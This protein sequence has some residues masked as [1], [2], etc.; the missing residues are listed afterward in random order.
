MSFRTFSL[1]NGKNQTLALADQSTRIFLNNPQGLGLSQTVNVTQFGNV[2]K[3]DSVL[4]FPTITGE[5]LFWADENKNIYKGY[6]D[7]VEFLSYTPLSLSYTIPTPTPATYSIDVE[8]TSLAKSQT[9]QDGAMRC[10]FNLTGLSR[11][12]GSEVTVTGST[13][14]YSLT[15]GGHLPVGFWIQIVGTNIVNPYITLTKDG[16]M[17]GE[18][19]FLDTTGFNKVT[20]DSNDG[21]QSVELEQGGSVLPN[22]LGFQDLSISNGSIY[23]TFVRLARGTSTLAIGMDSGSITSVSIKFTPLFASV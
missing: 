13:S 14:S 9:A 7:F 17:Y 15:N 10:S 1:K 8:L 19:K 21:Q 3:S 20:V 23:V 4:Q 16:D 11:W 6:N 5:I 2:L 12:K 22:P 18:A